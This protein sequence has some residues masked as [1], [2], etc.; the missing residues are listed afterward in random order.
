M[1]CS[2]CKA[3][4]ADGTEFCPRCGNPQTDHAR[5]L[6]RPKT[7]PWVIVLA[8]LTFGLIAYIVW[9]S[10][11]DVS[12]EKANAITATATVPSDASLPTPDPPAVE[13][14]QAV[15]PPPITPPEPL[16][17][18]PRGHFNPITNGALTIAAASLSWYPFTVPPDVHNVAVAGHFTATGGTGNDVA[19]YIVDED[20]LANLK[21]RHAARAYFNSG[22]VTQGLIG[23]VLPNLPATYYLVFDNR[24]SLITPKA[25]QVNATLGFMQ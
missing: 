18:T 3:D 16:P 14:P 2:R 9:H 1:T 7:Q 12:K 20:G 17:V 4:V 21:N 8:F 15:P 13:T 22:K 5:S 25:V 19:V 23:A 10:Y 6:I 11:N 24:F